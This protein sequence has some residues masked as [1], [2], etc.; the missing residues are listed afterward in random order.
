MKIEREELRISKDHELTGVLVTV[1]EGDGK[2]ECRE[3]RFWAWQIT[4]GLYQFPIATMTNDHRL[5]LI[6]L[7]FILLLFSGSP[8]SKISLSQSKSRCQQ[9]W[10]LWGFRGGLCLPTFFSWLFLVATCVPWHVA[11]SYSFKVYHLIS[12]QSSHLFSLTLT[13]LVLL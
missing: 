12:A 4:M 8:K 9:D 11:P 2:E 5:G 1:Y 3:I 13:L 10:L 6:Q 7:G